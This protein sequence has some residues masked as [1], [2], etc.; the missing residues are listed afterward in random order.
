MTA[1]LTS[2]FAAQISAPIAVPDETRKHTMP[3]T[4]A[5]HSRRTALS[6][7]RLAP[8]MHLVIEDGHELVAVAVGEGAL[9]IGRG[10]A[11]DIELED[12]SISRRHAVLQVQDGVVTIHDDR[13]LN[14]VFVN[15]ERVDAR[16]LSNGDDIVL[17]RVRLRLVVVADAA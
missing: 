8:G 15:G 6:L 16:V 10:F 13:S 4:V 7:P 1:S 12:S 3:G 9:R 2:N 11:C 5:P 14:G 17:G